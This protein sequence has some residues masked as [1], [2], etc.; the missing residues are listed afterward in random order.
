MTVPHRRD[1]TT[2]SGEAGQGSS[3]KPVAAAAA[4]GQCPTRPP[5]VGPLRL[6]LGGTTRVPG[7][8]RED[9]AEIDLALGTAGGSEHDGETVGGEA[10]VAGR[11]RVR[12]ATVHIRAE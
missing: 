12:G 3:Q 11:P 6:L 9:G 2:G 10:V 7:P 4:A 5:A 8:A 1:A